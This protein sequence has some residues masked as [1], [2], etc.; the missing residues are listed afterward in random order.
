MFTLY[1]ILLDRFNVNGCEVIDHITDTTNLVLL[2][3]SGDQRLYQTQFGR[4]QTQLL[5]DQP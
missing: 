5:T 3:V 1:V 4:L 2:Y